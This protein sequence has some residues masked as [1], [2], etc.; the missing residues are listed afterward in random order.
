MKSFRVVK[1]LVGLTVL[2]SCTNSYH[3]F[4][5]TWPE[6][7]TRHWIGPE[8]WSNSIQDWRLDSGRLECLNSIKPLRTVQLLPRWLGPQKGHLEMRV[9]LGR[10]V[11]SDSG[12]AHAFAGFLIGS[13]DLNMDFRARAII[14]HSSG[15]NGGWIAGINERGRLLLLDNEQGLAELA[16]SPA[17][18]APLSLDGEVILELVIQPADTGYSVE[19]SAWDIKDESRRQTLQLRV[20]EDE[21][22]DGNIALVSHLV[23]AWFKNWSMSGT[24][25]QRD[26]SQ[27]FGPI[28]CA[29]HTLSK[30]ILKMTAQ[31][32]PLGETD[33]QVVTLQVRETGANDW[34]TIATERMI[35]PGWTVPFTI[36]DWDDTKDYDYRLVYALPTNRGKTKDNY[37]QGTIRHNPIE[38]DELVVAAFTG[39]SNSHGTF[40]K[41]FDFTRH[42]IFF[43]H[44]DLDA[45]VQ[46]VNPDFLVYTGDQVYEGRPTAPDRSGSFNSYLDYLYKW[47]LFCWAHRDLMRDIPTV[48]MPDDHDVYHGNIWGAGGK[49]A[50]RTPPDGKYPPHYQGFTSHWTQDQ[51][52]YQM[53]ADFVKMVERTQ[54]SHLPDPYDPTPVE[55][56]IGVYYTDINYGNVSF[57]VL[58]DRKFKSAPSV[59]I[60]QGKVINGFFQNRNFNPRR[61]DVPGAQLLGERQELFLK[62]WAADWRQAMMKVALSQTIFANVTTYPSEFATDAGTPSL[63]ALPPDSIPQNYKLAVDMDSNGWP[64][65]GRNRA[66]RELRKGFAFMIAGDQHLGSIVHHGVDEWG[67]AGFSLCVPSIANLW[68]RRWYPPAPGVNH[69]QGFPKY[70]GSFLDGF[71][72]RITVWAVSNPVVS[73]REPAELHDRAP[74]F[75]V[76]RLNKKTQQITL[77]CWPRYANPADPSARQYPGWPMT[78][79]VPDNYG[80]NPIAF[81]PTLKFKGIENPVVQVIDESDQEIVYTLRIIADSFRPPVFRKGSYSVRVG[82]P[83]TEV[84]RTLSQIKSIGL[85]DEAELAVEF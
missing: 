68:P 83:G 78:I 61:A 29:M 57:A 37:Y 28:L 5:S 85:Q 2:A 42:M 10:T 44:A 11:K 39:N 79:S 35:V 67:D 58:E 63:V 82:E 33:P 43:P 30:G 54:T 80:R 26:E 41:Y 66:L 56:G 36:A 3:P 32:P 65:S 49:A 23:P 6:Q 81:L 13:G 47:Y 50:P 20:V 52:G 25:L 70:T 19:L 31:M 64:Q 38:K 16:T 27:V 75:G 76:V 18:Q 45:H 46:A 22:L 59:M 72:N 77:E 4:K 21:R 71:G 53:P 60:P 51:G 12:S 24:K 17:A 7:C 9:H 55:Q 48:C 84:M 40:G 1:L 73:G 34:R 8:Y 74:G 14:H 15:K 69:Q 62:A